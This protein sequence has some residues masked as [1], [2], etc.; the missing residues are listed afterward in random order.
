MRRRPRR[1]YDGDEYPKH[2][3]VTRRGALR[4]LGGLGGLVLLGSGPWVAALSARADG[5]A[6]YAHVPDGMGW[7]AFFHGEQPVYY[8]VVLEVT[9]EGIATCIAD[10]EVDIIDRIDTYLLTLELA[11]IESEVARP[12]IEDEVVA[13]IAE[14][15]PADDPGDDDSGSADDD[16]SA[17]GDLASPDHTLVRLDLQL[18][19]P[20]DEW[21]VM[22][23][24]AEPSCAC[25]LPRS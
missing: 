11:D 21:D 8:R 13:I 9:D 1:I 19:E 10:G 25:R 22:G 24:M 16:D 6:W 14:V 15:C 4:R 23:I 2:E 5:E 12:T 18:T 17:G 7:R 20:E 3:G